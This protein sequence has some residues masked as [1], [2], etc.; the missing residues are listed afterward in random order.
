M[1]NLNRLF[2]KRTRKEEKFSYVD[3]K[4]KE[5]SR[6]LLFAVSYPFFPFMSKHL[7]VEWGIQLSQSKWSLTTRESTDWETRNVLVYYHFR[8]SV[9]RTARSKGRIWSITKVLCL[10]E[11]NREGEHENSVLCTCVKILRSF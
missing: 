4:G 8:F 1:N 5:L 10:G 11:K 2:I 3:E 9:K 6:I 7:S